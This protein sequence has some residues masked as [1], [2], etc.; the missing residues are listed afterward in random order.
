MPLEKPQS[1]NIKHFHIIRSFDTGVSKS[2]AHSED[3]KIYLNILGIKNTCRYLWIGVTASSWIEE[4]ID[5]KN[6][7]HALIGCFISTAQK[8]NLRILIMQVNGNNSS[9][10]NTLLKL[11]RQLLP[12]GKTIILKTG[13]ISARLFKTITSVCFKTNVCFDFV[14]N[15]RHFD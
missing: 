15:G 9:D 6:Y 2:K 1:P 13:V 3:V 7:I 10:S 12:Y 14:D 11:F 8:N 5:K 4:S